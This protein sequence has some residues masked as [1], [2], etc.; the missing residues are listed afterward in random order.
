VFCPKCG[1]EYRPEFTRCAECNVYLVPDPP[2]S[3]EIEPEYIEYEEVL[4]TYSPSDVAFIKSL[5]DAEGIT[6]FFQ[7]ETVSPLLY[8]VVPMRL[9]VKIDEIE[10]ATE[11]LKDLEL[12]FT[13]GG[14]HKEDL[15]DES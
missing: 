7:G 5:L 1:S 4:S 13:S 11:L 9:L 2:P 8:Y 6:Y 15:D 14:P 12:S 3:T 10:T